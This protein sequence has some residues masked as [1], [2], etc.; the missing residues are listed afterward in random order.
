MAA[1]LGKLTPGLVVDH[2][3]RNRACVNP[4]HLREVTQRDNAL[5]RVA[6]LENQLHTA[7]N[8]LMQAKAQFALHTDNSFVDTFIE[9][10]IKARS[11][12]EEE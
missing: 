10:Y 7:V 12:G 3:C 2:V 6:R 8:Y 9:D 4:S 1:T 5:A 11:E